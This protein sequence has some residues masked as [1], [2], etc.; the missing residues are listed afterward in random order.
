MKLTNYIAHGYSTFIQST[1]RLNWK[2][3]LEFFAFCFQFFF[4]LFSFFALQIVS[5]IAQHINPFNMHTQNIKC[6]QFFFLS[7]S[8]CAFETVSGGTHQNATSYKVIIYTVMHWYT[9]FYILSFHQSRARDRERER[10]HF[11]MKSL[12]IFHSDSD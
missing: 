4:L 10:N 3:K 5:S 12:E 7:I 8:S 2:K 9:F 6:V 1:E 11:E